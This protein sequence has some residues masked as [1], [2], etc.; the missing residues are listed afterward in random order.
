[1]DIWLFQN[2]VEFGF[3]SPPQVSF[4]PVEIRALRIVVSPKSYLHPIMK[5][6][7]L[8]GGLRL[9]SPHNFQYAETA[10]EVCGGM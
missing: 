6:S 10:G 4:P 1:L 5:K 9:F 8:V 2:G 7:C 3:P